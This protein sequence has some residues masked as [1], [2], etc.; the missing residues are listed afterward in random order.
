[1][2]QPKWYSFLVKSSEGNNLLDNHEPTTGNIIIANKIECRPYLG[3]DNKMHYDKIVFAFFEDIFKFEAFYTRAFF[4]NMYEVVFG[5]CKPYFDIDIDKA[6]IDLLAAQKIIPFTAVHQIIDA[7]LRIL[8]SLKMP[9]GLEDFIVYSSSDATKA[10]YHLVIPR[11]YMNNTKEMEFLF[12]LVMNYVNPAFHKYIDGSIYHKTNQQ[13]RLLG[14]QKYK[15][16][17]FYRPTN[18]AKVIMPQWY[19]TLEKNGAVYKIVQEDKNKD[20]YQHSY[21]LFE[22]LVSNNYNISY[23]SE[24]L[25]LP[26]AHT[27]PKAHYA[28]YNAEIFDGE[29]EEVIK[30]LQLHW[31]TKYYLEFP[32]IFY[33]VV[34]GMFDLKRVRPLG[35]P[36]CTRIHDNDG[37]YVIKDHEG[38]YRFYCRRDE[39]KT[40][41]IIN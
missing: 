31:K 17:G 19:F 30:K 6:G 8:G 12:N 21:S 9:I 29:V 5:T 24:L 38:K 13:F 32:Y 35:C 18:R 37:A 1:M 14:S 39:T 40:S 15:F 23:T 22:S 33:R 34:S 41:I 4:P 28:K 10:S 2:Y 16:E 11:Y 25:A 26:I 20:K 3:R 36:I 7:L 27:I